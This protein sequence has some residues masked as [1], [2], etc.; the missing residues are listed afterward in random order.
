MKKTT[1]KLGLHKLTL[2]NMQQ[3]LMQELMGG[4]IRTKTCS[5]APV[6]CGPGASCTTTLATC[7]LP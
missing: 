7:M 4:I 3:E 1:K 6:T 2:A 5:G